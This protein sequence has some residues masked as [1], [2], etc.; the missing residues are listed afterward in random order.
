MKGGCTRIGVHHAGLPHDAEQDVVYPYPKREAT[1]SPFV[2][3][4]LVLTSYLGS[5]FAGQRPQC[6]L[7]YG[8]ADWTSLEA[9][10]VL[11]R[12][13]LRRQFRAGG[14]RCRGLPTGEGL[15]LNLF[16]VEFKPH[17][18]VLHR[19]L[20]ASRVN[21]LGRLRGEGVGPS[22]LLRRHV[23]VPSAHGGVNRFRSRERCIPAHLGLQF[24]NSCHRCLYRGGWDI[25]RTSSV[26][27]QHLL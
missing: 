10:L 4:L 17:G 14:L 2:F 15:C 6:W 11:H 20:Q 22:D 7:G 13:G 8:E 16:R 25:A 12:F 24:I 3:G 18:A 19:V 5:D 1:P 27:P 26:S 23:Q 21:R 9:I